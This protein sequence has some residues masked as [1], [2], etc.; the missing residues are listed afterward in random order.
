MRLSRDVAVGGTLAVLVAA[1]TVGAAIGGESDRAPA[2]PTAP[3]TVQEAI[4]ELEENL[5]EVTTQQKLERLEGAAAFDLPP[6]ASFS[7]PETFDAL[8]SQIS[9]LESGQRSRSLSTSEIEDLELLWYEDGFFTSLMAI[10]W[11]CAWLS[12]GAAHVQAGNLEGVRE[13]VETLHT[14]ASSQYASSF[15]Y[16]PGF[17]AEQVDPL[18]EGDTTGAELFFPNCPAS[19]RV[20]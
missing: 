11:Q 7:E 2:E 17:L 6:G 15:E 5:T 3:G 14:F 1:G 4:S 20:N 19:T 8:E 18:L 16:Y 10:D 12:A 9:D 13:A